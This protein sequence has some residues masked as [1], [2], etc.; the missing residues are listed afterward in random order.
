MQ[1]VVKISSD[2]PNGGGLVVVNGPNGKPS[3]FLT[4]GPEGGAVI[5]NG[6]DGEPAASLPDVGFDRRKRET[7]APWERG[8]EVSSW[9]PSEKSLRSSHPL[10]NGSSSNPGHG[11]FPQGRGVAGRGRGEAGDLQR[12][13]DPGWHV[14]VSPRLENGATERL[15]VASRCEN[16]T[17]RSSGAL[18]AR[19]AR[20]QHVQR[21]VFLRRVGGE[22]GHQL[23]TAVCS[24]VPMAAV[25]ARL[26]VSNAL[27][28]SKSKLMARDDAKD[29]FRQRFRGAI[30]ELEQLLEDDDPKWYDFG[31]SRP[32]DPATPGE[33]ID[34]QASP[35][36][37]GKI[38]AQVAGSRRSNSFNFYKQVVGTDL[39]P[40][41]VA[42]TEG[43]QQTIEG[44]TAGATVKVTVAGVNDAGEGPMSDA[45]SVVVT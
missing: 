19:G 40:V 26:G 16:G 31:L 5:V 9:Q 20:R 36:G 2:G 21:R 11:V 43:T 28:F 3:A 1:A 37:G 22:I 17:G 27:S 32:S 4:H 25:N 44:L 42:N 14:L 35:I 12:E 18:C 39:E 23:L 15:A 34:L 38:L 7:W 45:V 30:G 33:V 10:M 24:V 41:K 13:S 29:A 8:L 6:P